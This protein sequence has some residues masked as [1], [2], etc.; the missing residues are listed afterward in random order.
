MV[1]PYRYTIKEERNRL[2]RY[3]LKDNKKALGVLAVTNVHASSA[4]AEVDGE[5]IHFA[6]T[7]IFRKD[8]SAHHSGKGDLGEFSSDVFSRGKLTMEGKVYLWEP[9]GITWNTWGW[10]DENGKAVLTI[11]LQPGLLTLRGQVY[12]EQPLE[13]AG[14][15]LALFGWYLLLLNHQS[16]GT[17]VA[18]AVRH[19]AQRQGVGSRK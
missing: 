9:R 18:H 2:R 3:I 7:K 15:K 6:R 10:H 5:T 11:T 8:V 16:F 12:A 19:L 14:K 4:T 13:D 1:Q 17:H